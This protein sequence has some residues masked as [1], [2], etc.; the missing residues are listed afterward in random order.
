MCPRR[1]AG[2]GG[3]IAH[4]EMHS[5]SAGKAIRVFACIVVVINKSIFHYL[6]HVA[7]F[8]FSSFLYVPLFSFPLSPF[9]YT[10]FAQKKNTKKCAN[11]LLLTIAI[12]I[13]LSCAN[14]A[15]A[16]IPIADTQGSLESIKTDAAR[17]APHSDLVHT[18][19][20]A[21][22]S[23][24][25]VFHSFNNGVS[26]PESDQTDWSCQLTDEHPNPVIMLHG[27]IAPSFTR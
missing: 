27:L 11:T 9:L 22:G 23:I 24:A 15:P 19:E 10:R 18:V 14:A 2:N 5:T 8:F 16:P 21:L 4:F 3:G 7:L 13:V 20:A 1:C 25:D 6:Y 26:S 17:P 12:S